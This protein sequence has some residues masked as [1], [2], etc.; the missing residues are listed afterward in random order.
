MTESD[1]SSD[2]HR[3]NPEIKLAV[4]EERMKEA[5]ERDRM[6]LQSNAEVKE[7]VNSIKTMLAL[8]EQRIKSIE[9]KHDDTSTALQV[10]VG[11][12]DIIEKKQDGVANRVVGGAAVAGFVG[13]AIAWL[14]D[15]IK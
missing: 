2:K 1:I 5:R 13:T 7:A 8:G 9:D 11:R 15:L 3:S 4:L 6:L 10:V 12:V 14:K